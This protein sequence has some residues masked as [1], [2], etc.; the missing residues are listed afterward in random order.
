[1]KFL[2]W[3]LQ[4]FLVDIELL[5]VGLRDDEGVVKKIVDCKVSD[6]YK[7]STNKVILEVKKKLLTV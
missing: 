7:S 5:K 2:K 6:I 1:M 3:W 4:S